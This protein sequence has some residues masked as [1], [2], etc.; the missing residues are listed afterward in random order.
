MMD[1]VFE[2]SIGQTITADIKMSH[3]SDAVNAGGDHIPLKVLNLSPSDALYSLQELKQSGYS[4]EELRHAGCEFQTLKSLFTPMQLKEA[5]FNADEFRKDGLTPKDLKKLQFSAEELRKAGIDFS[6]LKDSGFNPKQLRAAG[7]P[8]SEFKRF[9]FSAAQLKEA[10]FT[11]REL[12]TSRSTQKKPEIDSQYHQVVREFIDQRIHSGHI[13]GHSL[14]EFLGFFAP[15]GTKNSFWNRL[16]TSPMIRHIFI[17]DAEFV[18]G[19]SAKTLA[20]EVP[21]PAICVGDVDS[22]INNCALICA[23]MI[24]IPSGLVTGNLNSEGFGAMMASGGYSALQTCTKAAIE[25]STFTESCKDNFEFGFSSLIV[26][27]FASFY[28]NIF[29]LL[30]AV[31]YYMCR[32]AESYNIASRLT[33]F[34]AFTLEVRRSI[35]E[36]RYP[37]ELDKLPEEPF[38]NPILEAEVF[39]KASFFALNEAEEQKNQV[40]LPFLFF[41]FVLL[42]LRPF[43][44]KEFYMWY[45]SEIY[46][47]TVAHLIS[48]MF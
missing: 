20:E 37:S 42:F 12:W 25:N 44:L 41:F 14:L 33:L 10:G 5:G 40:L 3:R 7:F 46:F 4:A 13:F 34:E 45:K 23:L 27:I 8:A 1:V 16:K 43:F 18:H 11:A 38:E 29:S 17:H 2:S 31:C 35:R 22:S 24:S 47:A 28:S 9:G 36:K 32:P 15:F 48:K 30:L 26:Y 6:S 39:N 19:M 21:S